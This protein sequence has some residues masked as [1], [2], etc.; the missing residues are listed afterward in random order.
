MR[1]SWQRSRQFEVEAYGRPI[2]REGPGGHGFPVGGRFRSGSLDVGVEG[3]SDPSLSGAGG[4][5]EWH[6]GGSVE[7]EGDP[8][9]QRARRGFLGQDPEPADPLRRPEH[10]I[11]ETLT[12]ARQWT[13]LGLS[14]CGGPVPDAT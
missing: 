2:L 13:E 7:L 4:Q 5:R 12:P 14:P 6:V 9:T 3:G 8:L 1:V 10:D 11:L